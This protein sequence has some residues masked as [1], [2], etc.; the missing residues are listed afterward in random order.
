MNK[1]D[2]T[3]PHWSCAASRLYLSLKRHGMVVTQLLGRCR[4]KHCL[5]LQGP[6]PDERHG[7]GVRQVSAHQPNQCS[8]PRL[9]PLTPR[10][11]CHHGTDVM[12]ANFKVYKSQTRSWGT[13]H[14]MY[15][16]SG[17][18][19]VHTKNHAVTHPVL[20]KSTINDL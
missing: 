8:L 6:Q 15:T 9:T 20:R 16:T 19:H 17:R 3:S 14:A 5:F 4:T 11:S 1:A 10:R 2:Q 13:S 12:G 18:S 7:S